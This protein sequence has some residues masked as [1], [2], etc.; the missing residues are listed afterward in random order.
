MVLV[1]S[2][3]QVTSIPLEADGVHPE[4]FRGRSLDE[5]RRTPLQYGNKQVPLAEFFNVS[6]SAEDGEI[7]WQGDCSRVK[8]IGSGL[9]D[10]RVVVEGD[11]GM[12]LGAEM[13]GGEILVRGNAGDWVGAEMHGGRIAIQGDAGH[14]V[15]GVY[16]GGR[17]GMTGGEIFIQGNA[18]NEIGHTMRRGLIAIGGHAG[19]AVG[20]NMIAGSVLVFGRAGR[21]AGAGMRRGTI[22]LF[23]SADP[24]SLLPTFK[25]TG[26][27]RPTFLRYLFKYL[28]HRGMSFPSE[29][30]D[31]A[32][33]RYAGDFLELG[34]GEILLREAVAG[35]A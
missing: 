30:W 3:R 26:T 22:G 14:L 12:H 23:Q 25:Y 34:K 15:G 2:V 11:A 17:R 7:H 16:R 29:I 4:T 13:R 21:R 1:L 10:G 19:D 24:P 31:V 32:Y 5:I 27:S 35:T 9:R 33:R 8:L 18:G 28:S 20:F 6:G